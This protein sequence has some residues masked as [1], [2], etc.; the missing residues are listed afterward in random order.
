ME[1]YEQIASRLICDI[2]PSL[3]EY[4]TLH[5][6]H[7]SDPKGRLKHTCYSPRCGASHVNLVDLKFHDLLLLDY[8]NFSILQ[9]LQEMMP[10]MV[11]H[12]WVKNM[13]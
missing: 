1:L 9:N 6:H 10:H 11:R 2:I 12:I 13:N 7:H 3:S 5:H 8:E 4:K